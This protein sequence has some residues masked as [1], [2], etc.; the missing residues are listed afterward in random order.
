MGVADCRGG[1]ATFIG[2]AAR[3]FKRL[4]TGFFGIRKIAINPVFMLDTEAFF[5]KILP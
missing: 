4:I 5:G 2:S 1:L 3:P